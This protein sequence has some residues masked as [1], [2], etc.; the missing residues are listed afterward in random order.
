MAQIENIS[1]LDAAERQLKT[2]IKF[3]F[4]GGDLISIHTLVAAADG[5]L[6][7]LCKVK[8]IPPGFLKDVELYIKP[9]GW[10]I[11]FQ[12]LN[13]S[14]N[15]FKHANSDPE[16]VHNLKPDITEG[17]ILNATIAHRSLTK[18]ILLESHIYFMWWAAKNP[19]LMKESP[20]KG[21][22]IKLHEEGAFQNL[23]IYKHMLDHPEVLPENIRRVLS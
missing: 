20:E 2:A 23:T 17:L 15:F 1:K 12:K 3:F 19:N 21:V 14:Q 6:T 16:G 10:S 11:W 9:E 7:D 5:I 18:R 4:D 22:F 13:E 8:G